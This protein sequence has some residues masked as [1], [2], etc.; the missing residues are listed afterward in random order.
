RPAS[1]S[2]SAIMAPEMPAPITSTSA[3]ASRR[4]G[5]ARSA[6]VPLCHTETPPRTLRGEVALRLPGRE[7][8]PPCSGRRLLVSSTRL[9]VRR[10]VVVLVGLIA[11]VDAIVGGEGFQ[12]IRRSQL[13]L[14]L[15]EGHDIAAVL[16]FVVE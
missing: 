7:S 6:T 1:V 3:V 15:R 16:G 5:G 4:N 14:F 8:A 10:Y 2:D 13:Q 12:R 9:P 11:V